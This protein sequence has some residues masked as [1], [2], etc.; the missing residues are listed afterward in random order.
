MI[1]LGDSFEEVKKL[2]SNSIDSLVTDPPYGMSNIS[3]AAFMECMIQWC[4]DDNMYLPKAKGFMN[5]SWDGFVPP[6]G[7]WKEV[8]RVLK[9]GSYGLVFAS[10][11]TMDLMG[12]ALRIAGFEI[13][14]CITWLYGNGF[15]K[16]HDISKAI[17]KIKGCKR[18]IIGKVK[19][20]DSYSNNINTLYG[21]GK[22][23]NGI[24]TITAPSSKEAKIYNGYGTALKP[25][26]EPALL[27]RKPMK[28]SV[29]EN[30]LHWGVGGLNIDGCRIGKNKDVPASPSKMKQNYTYGKYKPKTGLELG[31]DPNIG[32]FPSNT[33][34]DSEAAKG[35]KENSRFFYTAKAS[36]AERSAGLDGLN[37]HPTVKPIEIMRYLSR[38]ITPPNGIILEPFLGS[39]TTAIAAGKEGFRI[40]GIEREKEYYD[41]ALKRIEYWKTHNH[42]M[43]EQNPV[44]NDQLDLFG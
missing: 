19:K 39:G 5:K 8:L 3:H 21:G 24:M 6:L 33:L 18:D 13:R 31:S 37:I 36:K 17:D 14:D 44:N 20:L 29:A 30:V 7:F 40:I 2:E 25:S 26:Y 4:K 9:P 35:L 12:L 32:R 28:K 42:A 43:T 22:N 16:S 10:S 34:F 41:I 23:H 11:R 38:L 27:I 1:I 15:P